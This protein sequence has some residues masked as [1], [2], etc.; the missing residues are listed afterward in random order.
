M[1]AT[2]DERALGAFWTSPGAPLMMTS[3]H[4]DLL[5]RPNFGSLSN[6]MRSS[7]TVSAGL[8]MVALFTRYC[9]INSKDTPEIMHS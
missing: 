9:T 4:L 1:P 3:S 8:A 7:P 2:T 5:A 6:S